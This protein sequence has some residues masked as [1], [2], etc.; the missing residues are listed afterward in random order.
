MI[1]LDRR[2]LKRAFFRLVSVYP[3]YLGAGVRLTHV[4][5]DLLTMEVEMKLTP[6]N[7][8]YVG[9]HFGGSLYSMCDPFFMLI[10]MEAL[11]EGFVVWDQEATIRFK[12]PG[13]GKVRARFSVSPAEVESIRHDAI[14]HRKTSPVFRTK[15]TDEQGEVVAEIEK[16]LYVRQREAA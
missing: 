14:K 11:G 13:R 8:N 9:T 16:T 5:E 4:A 6:L 12:K 2:L 7:R 1:S 10:L 15:V 3:P